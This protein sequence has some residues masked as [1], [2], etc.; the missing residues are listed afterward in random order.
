MKFGSL[1][2]FSPSWIEADKTKKLGQ[3]FQ[4][5][6]SDFPFKCRLPFQTIDSSD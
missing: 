5:L 1:S 3:I 2:D 6:L 4:S